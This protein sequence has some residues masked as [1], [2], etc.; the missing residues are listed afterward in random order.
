VSSRSVEVASGKR[1]RENAESGSAAYAALSVIIQTRAKLWRHIRTDSPPRG[2]ESIRDENKRISRGGGRGGEG[3][4]AIPRKRNGHTGDAAGG[5]SDAAETDPRLLGRRA[6]NF[7]D[8][9]AADKGGGRKGRE[10]SRRIARGR[11]SSIAVPRDEEKRSRR[12]IPASA[13]RDAAGEK[14]RWI[15][16]EGM[17]LRSLSLSLSLSVSLSAAAENLQMRAPRVRRRLHFVKMFA[18]TKRRV[19]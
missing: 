2:R 19:K 7:L 6:E 1:I 10:K 17:L 12:L 3:G 5:R 13:P 15:F 9:P 16:C 18:L 14:N 8:S 4:W 11:E